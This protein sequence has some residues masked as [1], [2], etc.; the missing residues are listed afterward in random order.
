M[1]QRQWHI[2]TQYNVIPMQNSMC[3][4]GNAVNTQNNTCTEDNL[5]NTCK[6]Q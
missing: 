4:Q 2:Y 5:A 1:Y 3:I 6:R